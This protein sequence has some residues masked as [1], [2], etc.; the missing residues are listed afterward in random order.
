[1]KALPLFQ[2]VMNFI[3]T[4]HFHN[5]VR[6]R[7]TDRQTDRDRMRQRNTECGHKGLPELSFPEGSWEYPGPL[8][9]APAP[10]VGDEKAAE[11]MPACTAKSLLSGRK[12]RSATLPITH[13]CYNVDSPQVENYQNFVTRCGTQGAM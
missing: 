5:K 2:C 6:E 3:F 1:M 13:M 7:E 11:V 9:L 10:E 12:H 8:S 4:I